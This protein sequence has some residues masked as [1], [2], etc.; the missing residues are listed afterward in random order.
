MLASNRAAITEDVSSPTPGDDDDGPLG[1]HERK[2]L[3]RCTRLGCP[4]DARPDANQCPKHSEEEARR[5]RKTRR[6]RRKARKLAR[7]LWRKQNRCLGCGR[8]RLRKETRCIICIVAAGDAR[9]LVVR[10][11]GT[12]KARIEA[13]TSIDRDGRVRYRGQGKRGRQSVASLDAKDLDDA[14]DHLQSGI[15]GLTAVA[16]ALANLP[17]IQREGAKGAALAELRLAY[18][19]VGEVLVRHGVIDP[20]VD[21]EEA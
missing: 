9:T 10:S 17:R 16:T 1:Y 18:R 7:K 4:L 20:V 6:A 11:D 3:G 12:K 5:K 8:K 15:D 21:E 19:F 2:L 13:A 14:R